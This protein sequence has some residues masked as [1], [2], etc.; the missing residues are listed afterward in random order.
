MWNVWILCTLKNKVDKGYYSCPAWQLNRQTDRQ[1]VDRVIRLKT[2]SWKCFLWVE[3][4]SFSSQTSLSRL[5]GVM[6]EKTQLCLIS[7]NGLFFRAMQCEYISEKALLEK[8]VLS[9]AIELLCQCCSSNDFQNPVKAQRYF[10][11]TA[12]IE[13]NARYLP[14]DAWSITL[15]SALLSWEQTITVI[16]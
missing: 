1:K 6:E 16:E 5:G 14:E 13:K 3:Y 12:C 15:E 8:P 2:L 7:I 10:S 4:N 9:W 11:A